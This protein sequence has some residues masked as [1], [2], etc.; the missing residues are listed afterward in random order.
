MGLVM[1]FYPSRRSQEERAEQER[2]ASRIRWLERLGRVLDKGSSMPMPRKRAP[3]ADPD[4]DDTPRSAF[5]WG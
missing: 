1:T 3:K 5:R 2:A 4:S